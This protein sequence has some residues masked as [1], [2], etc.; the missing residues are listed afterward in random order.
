MKQLNYD[1]DGFYFT[2]SNSNAI[3]RISFS[4]LPEDLDRGTKVHFDKG[5]C[6]QLRLPLPR[7]EFIEECE[8]IYYS[9][10]EDILTPEQIYALKVLPLIR[11]CGPIEI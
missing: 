11:T 3:D 5:G 9:P 8:S 6:I 2:Y 7:E 10:L 1:E 4:E